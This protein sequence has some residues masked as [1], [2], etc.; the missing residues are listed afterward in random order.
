MDQTPVEVGRG[1]GGPDFVANAGYSQRDSKITRRDGGGYRGNAPTKKFNANAL[2]DV[3][4]VY[5][6]KDGKIANHTTADC[7]SLK[8]I[9]KARRAKAGNNG[10][11][12]KDNNNPGGF[13]NDAGSL[14]VFTGLGNRR[15]KKVLHRAVAVNA[16]AVDIPRCSTG[17]SS[18]SPRAAK[19]MHRGSSIPGESPWS[20]SPRSPTTGSPRP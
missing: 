19:T 5:H 1:D 14:H 4:C 16:V 13:G 20:S 8:E 11:Q 17:L 12:P 3:P 9:E 7:Y 2:L 6:N 10:D 15:E 18:P